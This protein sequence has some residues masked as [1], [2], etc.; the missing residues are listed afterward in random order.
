MPLKVGFIGC[1]GR[2]R[3][4]MKCLCSLPEVKMVAFADIAKAQADMCAEKF[5]GNAY[6]DHRSML[7]TEDLDIC[8]VCLPPFAHTDQEIL[9]AEKGIALFV[10]KPVALTMEKAREI[11]RAVEKAG[12]ITQVGYQL[13]F[14]K[15]LVATK[16]ILQNEGGRIALFQSLGY[17]RV[18]GGPEHWW[19]RVELSG[20]QL[21]EQSTH[22]VDQARWFVGEVEEVFAYFEMNLLKKLPNFN[23]E[24]ASVVALKFANGAIG[25]ITNT[26]ATKPG[27]KVSGFHVVAE[28]LQIN[29]F[30]GI[31]VIRD[32]EAVEIK[33]P[34]HD[35]TLE[36]NM[37]FIQSVTEG[38]QTRV[39]YSEGLKDL[40]VTLAAVMSA[41]TGKPTKLPMP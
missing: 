33:C 5:G 31:K 9:C 35:L 1:G 22:V 14:K 3:D 40:E 27:G 6:V 13:R 21:V 26:S 2:A 39:P 34:E 29:G 25:N 19:R 24:D 7:K 11:H 8:Y 32:G 4:H 18:A 28:N 23:I 37:H 15:E 10:E 16:D 30:N 36:A 17:G 38:K 12:V 20:G 41:R